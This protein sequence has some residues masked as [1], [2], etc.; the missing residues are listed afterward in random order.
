MC[1]IL[2]SLFLWN[3]LYWLSDKNGL[4]STTKVY[5]GATLS[6]DLIEKFQQEE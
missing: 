4:G 2:S 6:E 1:I 3:V 5:R